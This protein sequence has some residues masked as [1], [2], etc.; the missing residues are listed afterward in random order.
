MQP[1]SL[2]KAAL[3]TALLVAA[4]VAGWEW[5][6]RSQGFAISY[7]DDESLWASKRKLIYQTTPARPVVIGSSRIK[8]DLDQDTWAGLTGE[9]PVMLALVGTSPRPVLTDLGKDV[10]FKGTVIVDVV[11]GIFFAPSG[12]RQEK[13]ALERLK[14]YPKWSLAQQLSFHLN[15]RLESA[16]VFL[17]EER[18]TL[19]V[20]LTRLAVPNR[21]GVFTPPL[22]PQKF[23]YNNFDRQTRMTDK[24][25]ADTALQA[26]MRR[27]WMAPGGMSGRRGNGGDTLTALLASVKRSVDQIRARGGRVVFVRCPSDGPLRAAENKGYPRAQY[28]DRLLADTRTPGVHFADYPALARYR[29]PE[30]SHLTPRDAATFTRDLIPIMQQQTGWRIRL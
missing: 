7:N 27:V 29:C 4:F 15:R 28:W 6:W 26:Q 21:P 20:F 17:D 12:S 19:D 10:N 23:A 22:F 11:E 14:A 2:L 8:F 30:W 18:L 13:R 24:F 9:R 5:H 1:A 16:L 25:V 3:L